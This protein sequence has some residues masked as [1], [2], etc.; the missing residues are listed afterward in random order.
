MENK[1]IKIAACVVLYNPTEEVNANILTYLPLVD[2]LY[3]MDNS[4][5]EISFLQAIL[6]LPKIEYISLNGNKGI[7]KALKMA[8][9]Q[10]IADGFDFLLTM[11]QDSKYPTDDFKYVKNY[12]ST[13]EIENVGVVG[14][15][16]E[17]GGV[18]KACKINENHDK[19]LVVNID[20]LITSASII[21]LKNYQKIEGFK[22]E[23]FIDLVDFD[24]CLQFIAG[25][26][27]IKIMP[28]IILKHNL[29]KVKTLN[30]IF[31]KRKIGMH[32]PLRCYYMY[33]N[34][35]YL[36]RGCTND[37]VKK[38]FKKKKIYFG[39]ISKVVK[40]I[41]ADKNEHF[42][43]LKMIKRGIKDGKAG[44]LGEFKE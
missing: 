9:D 2:K 20:T 39:F 21:N 11:D 16:Y 40:F 10:A 19:N 34:Y 43:T 32:N 4:T 41:L 25:G 3:V 15:N 27:E 38:V 6:S 24:L 7:A 23:L 28:N 44:L 36:Y 18:V 42:K 13:K 22:P 30:L 17:N 8:A 35:C 29:G 12:L 37:K 5:K 31:Y 33:R 1:D 14:I 26:F